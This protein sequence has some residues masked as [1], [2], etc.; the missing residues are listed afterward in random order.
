MEVTS[1]PALHRHFVGHRGSISQLIF[2]PHETGKIASSSI[3]QT[4]MVWDYSKLPS[5]IKF[6]SHQD[7][8]YSLSWSPKTNL[9]ASASKDRTVKIFEPKIVGKQEHFMAH[10]K[11]VRSVHFDR[12]G[13]K[14]SC[15]GRNLHIFDRYQMFL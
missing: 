4:V 1:E 5:G 2:N 8:V 11:P 15:S 3:D 14:V 13:T 6:K 7:A 9:I 10:M 12:T